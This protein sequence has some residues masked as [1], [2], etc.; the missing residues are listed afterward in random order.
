MQRFSG[1]HRQK[2]FKKKDLIR[3]QVEKC[4][5]A[6]WLPS[7]A[8]TLVNWLPALSRRYPTVETADY[9]TPS[10][11]MKLWAGLRPGIAAD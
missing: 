5:Y 2:P 6:G 4:G 1:H 9:F 8:F 3:D 10:A 11:R 7:G